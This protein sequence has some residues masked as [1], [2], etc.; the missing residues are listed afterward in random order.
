MAEPALDDVA[1]HHLAERA[2]G[3][4]IVG[5]SIQRQDCGWHSYLGISRYI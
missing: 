2:P 1:Q 4:A 3:S 5:L